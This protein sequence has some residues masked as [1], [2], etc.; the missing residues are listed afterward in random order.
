VVTCNVGA[1]AIGAVVSFTVNV[2]PGATGVIFNLAQVSG[3]Q[4]DPAP[5]NNVAGETTTVV[6]VPVVVPMADLFVQ[7]TDTPDPVI[8]GESLEYTIFVNNFGPDTATNVTLTDTLPQDTMFVSAPGCMEAGGTVTCDLG[9]LADGENAIVTVAVTPLVVETIFNIAEVDSDT[10]DSNPFNN[11]SVESTLVVLEPIVIPKADLSIIKSGTPNP[12][13]V[14]STLTYQVVATNQGPDDATGV[15]VT[16]TLPAGVVFVSAT[17]QQGVCN[18]AAGVLTCDLGAL[19][20]GAFTQISI[21]VT[22][23]TTG[24]IVNIA[25]IAGNEFD[26]TTSNNIST[27]TTN[28]I[29]RPVGPPPD[30]GD[31]PGSDLFITKFASPSPAEQ[32]EQLVYT[33]SIGNLGPLDATGVTLLD[34]LPAGVSFVSANSSQGSCTELNGIVT[35]N[36]GNLPDIGEGIIAVIDIVVIPNGI[37]S[38]VNTA[39][40]SANQE[41]PNISNNAATVIVQ[42]NSGTTNPNPTPTQTPTDPGGSDGDSDTSSS[43]CSLIAGNSNASD[44]AFDLGLLLLPLF[45]IGVRATRRKK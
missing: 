30:G 7:K 33:V 43:G 8:A 16:D 18:Q 14:G 28:V 12:V 40:A 34:V 24:G 29:P 37:G 19:A 1:L 38:V 10:E 20:A 26:P 42:V 31:Q 22:P 45:I 11:I 41:D 27:E 3:D 13:I 32:G 2:T 39:V 17:P 6:D 23:N 5:G 44:S 9:D 4:F 25:Q 36:L 15:V 35:C 21:Q